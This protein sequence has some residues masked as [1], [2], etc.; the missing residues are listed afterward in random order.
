[1]DYLFNLIVRNN[2]EQTPDDFGAG[3]VRRFGSL[4]VSCGSGDQCDCRAEP[5]ADIPVGVW[6][7]IEAARDSGHPR[8]VPVTGIGI[9]VNDSGSPVSA[10]R[11]LLSGDTIRVGHHTFRFQRLR[12]GVSRARRSDLLASAAKVILALI[13]IGEL[14][15]VYWLP[16][17]LQES[18]VFAVDVLRHEVVRELDK[19]RAEVEL[20]ETAPAGS[21]PALARATVAEELRD[22]T[23][24][25]RRNEKALNGRQWLDVRSSM[26]SLAE[27]VR[28][29]EAGELVA[30]LPD[31]EIGGAVE[32]LLEK[33]DAIDRASVP[34]D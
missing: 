31:I 16:R 27:L 4:P 3:D 28:Q 7:R 34:S 14:G 25:V 30:P 11:E 19:L 5:E 32:K 18:Q 24:Y 10:P 12:S 2:L 20:K 9:F 21:L 13:F 6:F 23:T 22:L 17:Q 26:A 1:M 15:L 8:L 29:A 33:H